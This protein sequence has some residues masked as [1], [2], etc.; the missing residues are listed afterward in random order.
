MT[1]LIRRIIRNGICSS[2]TG[3]KKDKVIDQKCIRV[4]QH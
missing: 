1:M 4:D 3:K 2:W